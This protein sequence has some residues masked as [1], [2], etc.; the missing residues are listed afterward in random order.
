MSRE[1]YVCCGELA[2][3]DTE[4]VVVCSVCGLWLSWVCTCTDAVECD[5]CAAA[6]AADGG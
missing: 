6:G 4:D 3:M 5:H 2:G 1:H